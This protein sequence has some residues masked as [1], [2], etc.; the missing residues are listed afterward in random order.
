[1]EG[2]PELGDEPIG[3]PQLAASVKA[4]VV[5]G[6]NLVRCRAD[7][8]DR[9]VADL[10]DDVVADPGDL[11]FPARHL[12]DL[13]PHVLDLEVVELLGDVPGNVDTTSAEVD[14][15]LVSQKCW[16]RPG[17]AVEQFLYGRSSGPGNG[18]VLFVSAM[19]FSHL[20]LFESRA[21]HLLARFGYSRPRD[22]RS[23]EAERVRGVLHSRSAELGLVDSYR[24]QQ[25]GAVPVL[26]G[27]AGRS[28]TRY[29]GARI[30]QSSLKL[31]MSRSWPRSLG[32]VHDVDRHHIG[33]VDVRDV[34]VRWIEVRAHGMAGAVEL[35]FH[36]TIA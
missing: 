36:P 18:S 30:G 32:R 15:G 22:Q 28:A 21:S 4:D 20:S 16:Y 33:L 25:R 7:D 31:S 17:L 8:E 34:P 24:R 1:M 5:V 11:L 12:P 26:A 10:V 13:A 29:R 27:F 19:S 23:D 14:P 6:A 9:V 35:C 3:D 2:A